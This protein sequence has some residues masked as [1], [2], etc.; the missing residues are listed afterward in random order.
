MT[1]SELSLFRNQRVEIFKSLLDDEK[2]NN[3]LLENSIEIKA[4]LKGF[5]FEFFESF[6][7]FSSMDRKINED[8]DALKV[9]NFFNDYNLKTAEKVFILR[10]LRDFIFKFLFDNKIESFK[11]SQDVNYYFDLIIDDLLKENQAN[12]SDEVFLNNS[13]LIAMSEIISM[14][15]HQ[16]RQPLQSISIIVQKLIVIQMSEGSVSNESIEKAV[17]DVENQL[18]YMSETIEDFRQ[19]LNPKL[20]E[21]KVVVSD[22]LNKSIKFMKPLLKL[23]DIKIDL[24]IKNDTIVK[25]NEN[26]VIQV[27]INLIKNAKDAL[28]DKTTD[29]KNIKI[30]CDFNKNYVII[31]VKDNAGGILEENM[32]K[33]FKPYFTTKESSEGT[34]LGLYLSKM[35]IEDHCKGKLEVKNSDTGAKFTILLPKD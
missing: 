12:N 15:V 27:L 13:K 3:I 23:A 6:L 24:Q 31:A 26:N 16:W 25:T 17:N 32:G 30:T 35:I 1:K 4:F 11:L 18:K 21:E 20:K 34:G 29:E 19:F 8:F 2:V 33:I 22:M 10:L 9:L 5:L 28:A 7:T 14:V